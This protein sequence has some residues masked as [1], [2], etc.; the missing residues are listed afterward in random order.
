MSRRR[1]AAILILL[2]AWAMVVLP[3]WT[4]GMGFL[5]ESAR[6]PSPRD[7]FVPNLAFYGP[8]LLCFALLAAPKF[9]SPRS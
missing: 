8:P 1:L 4:I 2:S 9:K 3:G 5:E 7:G 6:L